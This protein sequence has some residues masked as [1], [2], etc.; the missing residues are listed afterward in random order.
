MG[1]ATAIT[2]AG[3]GLGAMQT[4]KTRKEQTK[5]RREAR[6]ERS[7]AITAAEEERKKLEEAPKIAEE[8][9]KA[10]TLKRRRA[11]SK[12]I[13]TSRKGTETGTLLKKT[14]GGA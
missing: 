11:R 9:A 14:L 4:R 12:T 3:L 7:R 10:E 5:L 2:L 8:K 13:L 1:I 6:S